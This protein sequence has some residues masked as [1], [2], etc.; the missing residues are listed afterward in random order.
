[1][2][3]NAG[4]DFLLKF[5]VVGPTGVGK[6]SILLRVSEHCAF[7]PQ[8]PWKIV[9]IFFVF[10][11]RSVVRATCS[12][13][14]RTRDMC[15]AEERLTLCAHFCAFTVHGWR[16]HR[17]TRNHHRSRV[18]SEDVECEGYQDQAT[19]MG[20]GTLTVCALHAACAR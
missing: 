14:R 17:R 10:V 2:A 20:H 16:V 12:A 11:R 4:Y 9:K 8:S 6:S 3:S 15:C 13:Q 5:I 18:W 7:P 1:M 19:D